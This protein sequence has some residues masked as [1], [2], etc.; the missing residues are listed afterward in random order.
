MNMKNR[1]TLIIL[2]A[3]A[4]LAL[5]IGLIFKPALAKEPKVKSPGDRLIGVFITKDYVDTFNVDAYINDNPDVLVSRETHISVDDS[6]KYHDRIYARKTNPDSD[7]YS[8][9]DYYFEGFE[10]IRCFTV[11]L[12]TPRAVPDSPTGEIDE[13][14]MT[15]ISISDAECS[16]SRHYDDGKSENG[17]FKP[18]MCKSELNC[19]IY[20]FPTGDDSTVGM[21]CNPVYQDND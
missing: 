3:T 4:I 21:Y 1:L 15:H 12:N 11:S 7:D 13:D 16:S 20:A 17:S 19:F 5:G 10:G 2:A 18:Q 6:P 14:Y 8:L 9:H